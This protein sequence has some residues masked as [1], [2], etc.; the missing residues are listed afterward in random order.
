MYQ[1]IL[2]KPLSML[3]C[4]GDTDMSGISYTLWEWVQQKPHNRKTKELCVKIQP[5]GGRSVA[6]GTW[7]SKK[8]L[9][10]VVVGTNLRTAWHFSLRSVSAQ[11]FMDFFLTPREQGGLFY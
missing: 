8:G 3:E 9:V 10:V 6:R 11:P 2:F 1:D 5:A 7:P 4:E